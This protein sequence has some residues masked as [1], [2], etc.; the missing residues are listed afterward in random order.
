MTD[1]SHPNGRGLECTC[2]SR[3]ERDNDFIRVRF[4]GNGRDT[5]NNELQFVQICQ[6]FA[7]IQNEM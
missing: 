4:E 2:I 1:S 6:I 3:F 7:S 5:I